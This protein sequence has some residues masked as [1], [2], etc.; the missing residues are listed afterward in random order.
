LDDKLLTAAEAAK[1][2]NVSRQSVCSAAAEG[3]IPCVWILGRYGFHKQ[4]V[5]GWIPRSYK[6]RPGTKSQGGR[7]AGTSVDDE[8]KAR[9]SESQK[10]RWAERKQKMADK[11]K[12]AGLNATQDTGQI[13]DIFAQD[14]V[15]NREPLDPSLEW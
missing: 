5:L 9:I 6:G 11:E 12:A 15:C 3:R 13:R 7:P 14:F 2:K 1:L 4:D 10:K 8:V